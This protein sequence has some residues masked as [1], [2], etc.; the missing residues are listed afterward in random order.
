MP[1][2]AWKSRGGASFVRNAAMQGDCDDSE[3]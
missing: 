2:R 1:V 3:N